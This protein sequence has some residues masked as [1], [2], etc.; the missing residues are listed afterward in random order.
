MRD[1]DNHNKDDSEKSKEDFDK[2]IELDDLPS[3]HRNLVLFMLMDGEGQEGINYLL[4]RIRKDPHDVENWILMGELMK[5]GGDD[6]K[7]RPYYE[8]ALKMAQDDEY[9]K[10]LLK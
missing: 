2:A 9:V 10:E 8:Q 1:Y 4:N 6:A 7:A 3:A 5:K